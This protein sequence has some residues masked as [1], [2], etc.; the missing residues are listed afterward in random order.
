M[1]STARPKAAFAALLTAGVVAAAPAVVGAGPEAL[2]TLSGIDVRPASFVT[3]GLLALGDVVSAVTDAVVIGTDLALGLNY[4]WDDSDFG[5]GVPFNPVFWAAAAVDNP[6][7]AVSYLLQLYLNPSNNY[8]DPS[9]PTT[10]Y[11]AYPWYVKNSVIERLVG[12]LPAQLATA[13]NDAINSVADGINDVFSTVLPDP[14]PAINQMWEQYNTPVGRMVYAVQ[15]TLALPVTL[16]SAVAFWLAYLPATVE[17]TIESAIATPADIPGLVSNLIYGVLDPDLQEGLLGNLTYNLLKPL[18]FLPAPIGE[19][20]FGMNDGLA[21]AAYTS[22]STAVSALLSNLPTPI[23]PSAFTASATLSS[24][25]P[26][27]ARNTDSAAP[28]SSASDEADVPAVESPRVRAQGQS[29]RKPAT[30]ARSSA[31][32]KP[33]VTKSQGDSGDG[34]GRSARGAGRG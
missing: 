31:A 6:G 23:T 16:G 21:Y 29:A 4:Y 1:L 28:Q 15:D 30:P 14:T 24:S 27:A 32:A 10:Y 11:Y 25:A 22:F 12:V 9:D 18:F 34:R 3:D 8:V 33:K 19:S 17:A 26:A 13:V 2:P 20:G 5:W 7:S